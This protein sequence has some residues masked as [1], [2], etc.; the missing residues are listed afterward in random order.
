MAGQAALL[1]REAVRTKIK[2]VECNAGKGGGKAP[3]HT[4]KTVNKQ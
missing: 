2:S 1:S 4:G 3:K